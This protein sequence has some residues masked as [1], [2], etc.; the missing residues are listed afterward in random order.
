MTF[1]KDIIISAVAL[2]VAALSSCSGRGE[3]D[4]TVAARVGSAKLTLEEVAEN[5]PIG[6]S[7]A[8]SVAMAEEYVTHWIVNELIGEIAAK[9]I[10]NLDEIDRLTEEYRRNL[11]I[12]EYRRLKLEQDTSLAVTTR[13]IEEYYANYGGQMRLEE[14]MVRGIFIAVSSSSPHL[15]GIRRWYASSR[16]DDIEKLE[17]TGL[18]EAITYEYFRNRW[19]PLSEISDRIPGKPAVTRKGQKIDINDGATTYLLSVSDYLPAGSSMPVSDTHLPL[20]PN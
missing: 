10:R 18:T 3:S 17:K 13:Q 19:M 5:L 6:V 16:P 1:V 4:P 2:S 12:E 8:D 14:P 7:G 15:S 11:I 9:N 20:P